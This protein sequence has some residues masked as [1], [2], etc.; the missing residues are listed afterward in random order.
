MGLISV[1]HQLCSNSSFVVALNQSD[2]RYLFFYGRYVHLF[3]EFLKFQTF[4]HSLIALMSGSLQQ[5]SI[6]KLSC[7]SIC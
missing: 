1:L 5:S 7:Y 6:T 4:F 2:L 3:E